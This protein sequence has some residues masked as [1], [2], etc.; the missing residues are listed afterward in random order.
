MK[1][2]TILFGIDSYF[3]LILAI[4]LRTTLYKDDVADIILYESIPSANNVAD[5]LRT[6][7]IFRNVW[8]AETSLTRCGSKYSFLKKLPKYFVYIKTIVL[9]QKTIESI[10]GNKFL[11]SYD[12]FI[13]N[14]FGALPECIF[15][16]AYNLNKN[17][18]CR[19]IE[20]GYMSYIAVY[21]TR[22][23]IYRKILE[24]V[25]GFVFGRQDIND[26]IDFYYLEDVDLCIANMPYK[27]IQAPKIS[28]NNQQLVE[29]LNEVFCYTPD[30]K[31]DNK[32]IYLFEDG[33]HFFSG[34]NEEMEIVQE[35]TKRVD[36][37]KIIVKM[38]PRR[39]INRWG[40][41][42]IDTVNAPGVPWELI[43]LN[44]NC[45]GKIFMTVSSAVVFS[46][47]LYFGDSCKNILL[48][49]CLKEAAEGLNENFEAY[50]KK[51]REKYGENSIY[52]PKDYD[53]LIQIVTSK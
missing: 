10:I 46:S 28:R 53:E 11:E 29:I 36:K 20:D 30:P 3:Q 44:S 45:S 39:T 16:A 49:K 38:H 50:V 17:I 1:S 42:D 12:E 26:Y 5:R 43:Q 24:T 4:N 34:S 27:L 35:I 25:C 32:Q 33:R 21:L 2:K 22:K 48:F 51:F 37:E 23:S 14:G 31:L 41:V 9:P 8:V 18:R 47:A 6:C 15:N 19:R 7:K 52:I 40:A 13:F